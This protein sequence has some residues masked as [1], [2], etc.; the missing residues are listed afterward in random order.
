MHMIIARNNNINIDAKHHGCSSYLIRQCAD[1]YWECA[2]SAEKTE[3]KASTEQYKYWQS[4]C[5]HQ[6]LKVTVAQFSS[7]K[8]KSIYS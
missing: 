8:S 1:F 5:L 3:L 2:D 4:N 7:W 6:K